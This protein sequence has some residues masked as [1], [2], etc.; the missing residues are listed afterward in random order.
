MAVAVAARQEGARV[1]LSE[2]L[3][4]T[5]T[6]MFQIQWHGGVDSHAINSAGISRAG[7]SWLT[8][9]GSG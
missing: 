8:L 9:A 6:C 7:Q 4:A 2:M 3:K 1:C 5:L